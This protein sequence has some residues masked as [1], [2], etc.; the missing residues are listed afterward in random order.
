MKCRTST[1][2]A[3]LL[4]SLQVLGSAAVEVARAGAHANLRA[5]P[6]AWA[7]NDMDIHVITHSKTKMSHAAAATAKLTSAQHELAGIGALL[8]FI[9]DVNPAEEHE[10]PG[11]QTGGPSKE[12][13]IFDV[14]LPACLKHVNETLEYV[15]RAYTD[16]NL[17]TALLSQCELEE[18]FPN[19]HEDGFK[20][21]EA[22]EVFATLLVEARN[23]DLDTGDREGYVY[24]CETFY[25][26]KGGK[27]QHAHAPPPESGRGKL[28]WILLGLGLL[29]PPIVITFI[30]LRLHKRR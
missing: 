30:Y 16:L 27:V 22:C 8:H 24:F 19:T 6:A 15:D 9:E 18:R 26:H 10:A 13:P 5:A 14:F 4:A 2:V 20:H 17:H 12:L 1:L 11:N 28:F 7:S 21:T 23:L 3:S 29:V 25:A